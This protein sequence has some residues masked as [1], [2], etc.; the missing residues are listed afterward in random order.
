MKQSLIAEAVGDSDTLDLFRHTTQLGFHPESGSGYAQLVLQTMQN[1]ISKQ[2]Y[3]YNIISV[4]AVTVA[5]DAMLWY[6]G[7]WNFIIVLFF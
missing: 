1:E 2:Y 5:C 7:E 4:H 6:T 3:V